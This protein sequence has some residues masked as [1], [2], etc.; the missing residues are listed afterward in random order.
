MITT[1]I[2]IEKKRLDITEDISTLLTFCLDDVKDFASRNTAFS[3]TI[4][5]PG[6]SNNNTLFGHIFDARV[7]N[8]YVAESDNVATNFNASVGAD[9]LIFQDHIQIFKGTLR[10]LEIVIDKGVPEYEC[11][12]FGELGGLVSALGSGR[13]EDLDFSA[14]DHLW[15][16]A[17]ITASWDAEAAGF[18]YP[19]IDYGDVS[20]NKID[21]DIRALRPALF[22][23]EYIDKMLTAAGFTFE[24]DLFE[25]S[26][27]KH[28]IIPH[29]EKFIRAEG[30]SYIDVDSTGQVFTPVSATKINFPTTVQMNGFTPSDANQHTFNYDDPTTINPNLSL[31][32][33]GLYHS[34]GIGINIQIF[35]QR[36]ADPEEVLATVQ[37][38]STF[39]TVSVPFSETLLVTANLIQNDDI[40]CRI[41]GFNISVSSAV[42]VTAANFIV[43]PPSGQAVELS[44]GG[45]VKVNLCIPKNIKQVDFLKS[46]ITLFNLYVYD[47][48]FKPKKLLIAPYVDFYDLNA[49]GVVDWTYKCDRAKVQRLR[50]M[51]ELNARF[52]EF[53][54][55][56]DSDYYNELYRSKYNQNYGDYL[57]DSGYEFVNDTSRADLIF[58]PSVLVGYVGVDKIVSALYKLNAGVEEKTA[59]NIRI[60][61]AKKIFSVAPWDIEDAGVDVFGG[62]NIT[63]YGYGGHYDD[64]DAP[65]NDIHFGVPAELFFTLLS[66]AINVTQFNVYWSS[67]MAEITDKDSKLLIAY[68]K[69]THKDIFD[70]D[71]SKLI[72]FDGSYWRLNKVEDWNANTPEVC[73]CE[74]LRVIHTIY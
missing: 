10:L 7:S 67:Y 27:F 45:A 19:L 39:G 36:G 32:I 25:T 37:L 53:K 46:I 3:K 62:S 41:T 34:N 14:Y 48:K 52:Y 57:Y 66:G 43:Q 33:S 13:L 20:T 35:R 44:A 40:Y 30:E 65:G 69:L 55:K 47:D 15:T 8:P 64:P 5:L 24:C 60:M 72:F 71:F 58:S 12:V 2:Y 73:R 22:V 38:P 68:F 49:S 4:V 9:C 23:R 6:T 1:E 21:Y 16:A 31:T 56:Q 18:Y 61:Q 11:A 17:E 74:I 59:T 70:L 54:F 63:E 50:P 42:S 51:S 26:R 28:L 29:N